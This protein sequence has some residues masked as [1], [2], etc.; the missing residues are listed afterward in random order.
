MLRVIHA[1]TAAMRQHPLLARTVILFGA[2]VLVAGHGAFL[3]YVRAHVGLSVGA[4]AG[5]ILL[6][7]V[8]HLGLLAPAFARF[9]RRSGTGTEGKVSNP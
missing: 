4:L 9:R 5:L 6:V 3:Y 7:L 2:V 1:G 8:K